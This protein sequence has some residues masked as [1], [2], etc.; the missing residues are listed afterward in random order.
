MILF[1]TVYISRKNSKA[2]KPVTE[3]SVT[4]TCSCDGRKTFHFPLLPLLK[5]GWICMEILAFFFFKVKFCFIFCVSVTSG[6][7]FYL[8]LNIFS[9]FLWILMCL[10]QVKIQLVQFAFSCYQKQGQMEKQ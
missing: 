2:Y 9:S 6:H 4:L 3:E 5:V 7:S 10:E 1:S 8:L